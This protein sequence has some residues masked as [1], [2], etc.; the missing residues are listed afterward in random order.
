MNLSI[1]QLAFDDFEDLKKNLDILR[2]NDI[3]NIEIVYAKIELNSDEYSAIFSHE[4][5]STKS[6]QSILFNSGVNDFL[7]SSF[8]EHIKKIIEINKNFGVKVLVLG[9]P[10]QRIE[11]NEQELIKQFKLIDVLLEESNQLLCIEPNC[12]IYGGS[13]FFTVNA[14]SKFIE[15]GNFKNIK[16]M[17][18]THN[19]IN[20][21]QSPK[22]V[23]E[24]Y[25]NLICHVHVSENG[26]LDFNESEEHLKLAETLR[27]NNFEGIVTYEVLPSINLENSL[28]KFN[29]IYR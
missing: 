19:I 22:E 14:I 9:S 5:I 29:E 10:K 7:S 3:Q 4:K 12:K 11:Y 17:I 6:T 24:Q 18:D 20:E 26:L 16:T 15:K 27:T 13:Y 25:K 2:K 21:G 8:V 28:M 23:Y 1:S